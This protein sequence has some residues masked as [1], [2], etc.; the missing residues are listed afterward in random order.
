[1]ESRI[2]WYSQTKVPDG[3]DG[4]G[5]APRGEVRIPE[6]KRGERLGVW[7]KR[8]RAEYDKTDDPAGQA[9]LARG[10]AA[11]AGVLALPTLFDLFRTEETPLA[12][13]GI[14]EAIAAVGTYRVAQEMT[15]YARD[16]KREHWDHALD[17]IYQCLE[18][19]ERNEK[20]RPFLRAVRAFTS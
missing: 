13:D 2:D 18:K 7:C 10:M 16:S 19:P 11:H 17:V 8:V 9:A 15:R 1:M 20:E 6:A 14:H 12:R 3:P 5:K 4:D